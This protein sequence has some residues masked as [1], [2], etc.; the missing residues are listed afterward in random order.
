MNCIIMTGVVTHID[1]ELICVVLF[2]AK[3]DRIRDK[4]KQSIH[5]V[6][7]YVDA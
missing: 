7:D 4:H 2:Y 5:D 1:G 6:I 3:H